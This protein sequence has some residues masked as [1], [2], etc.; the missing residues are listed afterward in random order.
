MIVDAGGTDREAVQTALV[1]LLGGPDGAHPIELLVASHP[2]ED[3]IAALPWLLETYA[4]RLYVDADVEATTAGSRALAA[5]RD[6]LVAEGALRHLTASEASGRTIELCGQW[7]VRARVL[8]PRDRPSCEN[9]NDCS[10]VVRVDFGEVSFLLMGDA[11][12]SLEKALL[13]APETAKVIDVDVLKV[14]HHGSDTSSTEQFL[15][16]ATIRCAV[17]SV[18]G[19]DDDVARRYGHPR[20]GTIERLNNTL[21]PAKWAGVR[22]SAFDGTTNEWREVQTREGLIATS[23]DGPL[24]IATDGQRL[25]CPE[26]PDLRPER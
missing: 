24:R 23:R 1:Q 22:M 10:V 4:V 11:E 2:H 3:H 25:W 5:V 16:A 13:R 9:I 15:A 17:I 7:G 18:G 8:T 14:A 26:Q 19:A 20:A 12:A 21:T 6:R